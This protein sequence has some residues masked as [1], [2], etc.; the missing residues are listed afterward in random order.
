VKPVI[1]KR[2][3]NR[4]LYDTA[5]SQ[6][7]TLDDLAHDLASGHFGASQPIRVL[8]ADTGVDLTRRTLVAVLLTDAHVHKLDLLPEDFLRTLIHIEDT[9]LMKLFAHYLDTTL[10]SFAIAQKAVS[11]NLELMRRLAPA[12]AELLSSLRGLFGGR[13]AA[14]AQ[15]TS[16]QASPAQAASAQAVATRAAATQAYVAQATSTQAAPPQAAPPQAASD[17]STSAYAAAA[18]AYVA[19]ATSAGNA[20]PPPDSGPDTA[21]ERPRRG[22]PPKAAPPKTAPVS[23]KPTSPK[24]ARKQSPR[25]PRDAQDPS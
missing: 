14:P 21:P 18:E 17:Q 24:S 9:S 2:Y 25:A 10:S 16:A 6:Y 11:Q 12:P 1:I 23:A 20:E 15:A 4:R 5:R 19:R 8:D 13:G 3:R 22:R 7:I